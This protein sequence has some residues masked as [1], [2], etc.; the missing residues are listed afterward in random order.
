MTVRPYA[1]SDLDTFKRIHADSGLDYKF[2]D[3]SSPLFVAKLV[4]ERNGEPT[5]LVM[6]KIHAETYLVTSGNAAERLK[7]IEELQPQYIS[8]LWALGIDNVFCGVPRSIDRHFAKHMERLG[9]E[10][11]RPEFLNWFRDTIV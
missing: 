8:D 1:E 11:G 3:L 2:P 9:W 6:G 10:R 4:V 5:S 7:D